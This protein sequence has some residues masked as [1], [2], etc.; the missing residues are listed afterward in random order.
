MISMK[1]VFIVTCKSEKR[2][3]D[4]IPHTPFRTK[5][6]VFTAGFRNFM[7]YNGRSQIDEWQISAMLKK[8]APFVSEIPLWESNWDL[9]RYSTVCLLV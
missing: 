3:G 8:E 4:H 2:F 6:N 1:N 7:K 9:R 5:D